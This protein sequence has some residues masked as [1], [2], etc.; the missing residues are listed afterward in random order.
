MNIEQLRTAGAFIPSEP[1]KTLVVWKEH[2]FDVYV[3]RL[4][5]GDMENLLNEGNS[6]VN[7]IAQA[8]LLGEDKTP[9]SREDAARLDV[10]LASKLLEAV[11]GVNAAPKP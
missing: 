10:S 5:F 9:I 3:R 7:L 8:V 2:S 1:V 11:N 6:T 4:S